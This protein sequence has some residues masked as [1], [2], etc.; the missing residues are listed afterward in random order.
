MSCRIGYVCALPLMPKRPTAFRMASSVC[1]P[2]KLL[3]Q[4][5]VKRRSAKLQGS[6][7]DSELHRA[8]AGSSALCMPC[9]AVSA[10]ESLKLQHSHSLS[11]YVAGA[12]MC[13]VQVCQ[14]QLV[15][16]DNVHDLACG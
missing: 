12:V 9:T 5:A 4:Q 14:I 7:S 8:L 6:L 11:H 15:M 13:E 2:G 1:A 10:R 3:Q 16:R